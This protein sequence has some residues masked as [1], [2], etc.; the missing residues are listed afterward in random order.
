[1]TPAEREL[2]LLVAKTA[3]EELAEVLSRRGL[4]PGEAVGGRRLLRMQAL[5]QQVV[6]EAGLGTDGERSQT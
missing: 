1:M 6:E 3:S 2:L 5:A 4:K